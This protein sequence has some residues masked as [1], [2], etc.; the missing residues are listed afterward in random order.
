[1][2]KYVRLYQF[3]SVCGCGSYT[4][5]VKSVICNSVGMYYTECVSLIPGKPQCKIK[6][7]KIEPRLFL[8][9]F[10]VGP[11]NV[12]MF[13]QR[14]HYRWS[15]LATFTATPFFVP[16]HLLLGG[17]LIEAEAGKITLCPWPTHQQW[18]CCP[19]WLKSH[20]NHRWDRLSHSGSL[21][22]RSLVKQCDC[23]PGRLLESGRS[24]WRMAWTI[25]A[26]TT[27]SWASFMTLS[28]QSFSTSEVIPAMDTVAVRF[29]W[30]AAAAALSPIL[31]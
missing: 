17:L 26:N 30:S 31:P 25:L 3:I 1:M 20:G 5:V 12:D 21:L 2:S 8:A 11:S 24:W 29:L 15:T 6:Q 19:R 9:F 7:L 22:L 27:R 18:E 16:L 14:P 28:W 23:S 4:R 13:S 10:S